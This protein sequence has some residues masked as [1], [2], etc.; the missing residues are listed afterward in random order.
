[1]LINC[2]GTVNFIGNILV[3]GRDEEE[4]NQRLQ[5]FLRVLAENDVLLYENN[6]HMGSRKQSSLYTS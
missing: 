2:K 4:H 6:A 5:N 3:F 1:M